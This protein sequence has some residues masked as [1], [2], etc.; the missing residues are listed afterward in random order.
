MS[1]LQTLESLT[2]K[3]RAALEDLLAEDEQFRGGIDCKGAL[4]LRY[5]RSP[6][7][8]LTDR[9]VIEYRPGLLGG[10][11]F[12]DRVQ[13]G[14][15]TVSKGIFFHQ[16]TFSGPGFQR[17]FRVAA[18]AG[19]KFADAV[20]SVEGHHIDD[21]EAFGTHATSGV[22]D[23]SGTH[24]DGP[25]HDGEALRAWHYGVIVATIAT[26]VGALTGTLWLLIFGYVTI[27]VTIYLDIRGVEAT[28]TM[29][30]PD[31]GLYLVGALIF[32]LIA[33]PMYLYRRHETV[34][35]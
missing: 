4:V 25:E 15:A 6:K 21:V 10:T 27:P 28:D 9:R 33:V 30:E 11:T 20:K 18:T 7:L 2:P 29:W 24:R 8:F 23:V 16:L 19:R 12:H 26:L 32:P 14:T 3:T 17:S 22:G 5:R 13:V 1:V 35:I 31:R 34:G